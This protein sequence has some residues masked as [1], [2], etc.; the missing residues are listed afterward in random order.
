M[1]TQTRKEEHIHINVR[2][3]VTSALPS[4]FEQ[5]HFAHQALPE[6]DAKEIDTSVTFLN[7]KLKIPLLISG[8]TGGTP[9]AQQINQRL[10]VVAQ[11]RGLAM[12]LGSMRVLHEK[13]ET[14]ASFAMR[15]TAP[16]L[17]LLLANLGAVQLNYGVRPEDCQRLVD[18]CEADALVLHLNPLQ[19]MLQKEGDTN[20]A[21]LLPKIERVVR[22]VQVPVFCKEVG[23]GFSKKVATH[24]A[25]VG[26]QGFDIAGAGGTSWSEV[27]AFRAP[28]DLHKRLA[29]SFI[30][31]GIPTKQ[32]L[33][34]VQQALPTTQ[35][36]ASG[37]IR[38][39]IEAAKAFHLGAHLVGMAAPFLKAA[40]QSCKALD[41]VV[42]LFDAQ[43]RTTMFC[44]GSRTCDDLQK[45]DVLN[46]KP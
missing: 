14:L 39:G 20:W 11:E 29:H 36:I 10:A 42:T 38:S 22:C 3:K 45:A 16:R 31:W 41:D 18:S 32:S 30:G 44:T 6:I 28:T 8:M 19:E 43:L 35:L 21:A 33:E 34:M 27:E 37:G 12:G 23:Y 1:S 26:V 2:E 25:Q 9:K 40:V 4:G 24:L 46:E 17:P 5:I 15:K 7:Q 13:P